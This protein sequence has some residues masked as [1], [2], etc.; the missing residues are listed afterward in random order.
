MCISWQLNPS[1]SVL[2]VCRTFLFHLHVKVACVKM[3]ISWKAGGYCSSSPEIPWSL[4]AWLH[5]GCKRRTGRA[6]MRKNG[7]SEQETGLWVVVLI[8]AAEYQLTEEA[9]QEWKGKI[10][11]RFKNRRPEQ[12]PSG[13]IDIGISAEGLVGTSLGI[14][15][16]NNERTNGCS[17]IYI[18]KTLVKVFEPCIRLIAVALF[19]NLSLSE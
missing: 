5:L 13:I 17:W 2:L 11:A 19:P 18:L 16:L 10:R 1:C 3:K 7:I 8:L 9:L 14:I 6:G 15:G 4:A 12:M